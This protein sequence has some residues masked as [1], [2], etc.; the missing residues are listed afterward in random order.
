M[1]KIIEKLFNIDIVKYFD[2]EK[3][4]EESEQKY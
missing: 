1:K 3:E 4:V 2:F